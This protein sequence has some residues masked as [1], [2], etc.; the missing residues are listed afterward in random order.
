MVP[1]RTLLLRQRLRG[2][3]LRGFRFVGG[4][5]LQIRPIEGD[6]IRFVGADFAAIQ[7]RDNLYLVPLL[8]LREVQGNQRSDPN[9]LCGRTLRAAINEWIDPK[10]DI[11]HY[12]VLRTGL[13]RRGAILSTDRRGVRVRTLRSTQVV[14]VPWSH[15][16][17]AVEILE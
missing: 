8:A 5:F 1:R 16:G 4:S 9:P 3:T 10:G 11:W 17:A 14:R 7:R 6:G 15:I 2:L 13:K 12:F